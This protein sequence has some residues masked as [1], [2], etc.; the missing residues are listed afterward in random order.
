MDDDDDDDENMWEYVNSISVSETTVPS[1]RK[2]E[3]VKWI[4]PP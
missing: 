1:N 4:L 3:S 2:L